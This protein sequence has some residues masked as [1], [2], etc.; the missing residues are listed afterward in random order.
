MRSEEVA[1]GFKRV[2]GFLNLGDGIGG[3]DGGFAEA[4]GPVKPFLSLPEKFQ[5]EN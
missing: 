1:R 2:E 3:S 4:V 5:E